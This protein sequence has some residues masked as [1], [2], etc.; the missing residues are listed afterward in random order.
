MASTKENIHDANRT[1]S[2]E[3]TSSLPLKG[4]TRLFSLVC[5]KIYK[6]I[7]LKN[8]AQTEGIFHTWKGETRK[9][10]RGHGR[11]KNLKAFP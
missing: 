2:S 9:T 4:S 1:F 5:L 8:A 10:K 3:Y 11:E 7:N 6:Q